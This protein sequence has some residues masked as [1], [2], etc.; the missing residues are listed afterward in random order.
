MHKETCAGCVFKTRVSE[1]GIH[2]PSIHD[3]DLPILAKEVGNYSKLLNFLDG[4]VQNKCVDMGNCHV[5]VDESSYL[6]WAELLAECGNLHTQKL[7]MEHSEEILNVKLLESSSHPGRD[8]HYLM[9]KR[10]NGQRKSVCLRRFRS[11]SGTDE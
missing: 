4:S 2:E 7:I 6:I 1:H 8:Q 5:L 10:S 9:T 11:M 3:E